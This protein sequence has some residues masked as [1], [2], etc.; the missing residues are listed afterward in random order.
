[1]AEMR[2]AQRRANERLAE[3]KAADATVCERAMEAVHELMEKLAENYHELE[4]AMSEKA[5]MSRHVIAEWRRETRELMSRLS[6]LK[7]Q[8]A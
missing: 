3:L 4:K 8:M 2:E 1:M 6:D 5:E 7:P